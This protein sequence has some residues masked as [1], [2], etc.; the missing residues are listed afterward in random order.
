ML[1]S[2]ETLEDEPCAGLHRTDAETLGIAK[3]DRIAIR[4]DTAT[5][6]LVAKLFDRM[7][8]GVVVIPRLRRLPWRELGKRIQRRDIHK[9]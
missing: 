6:E 9:V 5:V 2:L 8:P 1:G 3:G 4:T 7:A